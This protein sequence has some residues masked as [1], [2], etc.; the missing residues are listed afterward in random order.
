LR[1]LSAAKAARDAG[2]WRVLWCDNVLPADAAT[3]ALALGDRADEVRTE[4]AALSLEQAAEL[5]MR[6]HGTRRRPPTGWASLSPTE[7]EVV[8][9]VA[10]GKT[11]PEIA[12]SL[13]ISR[14]TVKTHVSHVLT[15]LALGSRS[16]IAAEF[17]RRG[18]LG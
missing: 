10:E 13:T 4:G 5:A 12:S 16:E 7:L 14:A 2:G 11:N 6:A 3:A 1:L 15:K 8:A 17:A 18:S 9:L